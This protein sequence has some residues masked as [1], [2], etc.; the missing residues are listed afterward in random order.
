[1]RPVIA[2]GA[3]QSRPA[4]RPERRPDGPARPEVEAEGGFGLVE[5]LI[6]FVL[7]AVGM[8]AIAGIALST[9]AQ[10]R[11]ASD[12]TQ[13]ALASQQAM[14]VWLTTPFSEV[15]TGGKDTTVSVAGRDYTVR[16]VVSVI[17]PRVKEIEVSVPGEG[18]EAQRTLV[19]R[20]RQA[21]TP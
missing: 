4:S 15:P 5:A 17:G 1:M 6:A 7:L 16:R 8:L 13:Q 19:S 2:N 9:A 18:S 10:T 11:S 20:L 14:E 3:G 12:V 21:R